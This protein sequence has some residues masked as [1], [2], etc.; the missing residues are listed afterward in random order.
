MITTYYSVMM[1][2]TKKNVFLKRI[3]KKMF[4]NNNDKKCISNDRI[5]VLIKI[6]ISI[7]YVKFDMI[8]QLIVSNIN[9]NFTQE[10]SVIEF[11][12]NKNSIKFEVN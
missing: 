6:S 1:K 10:K 2:N 5:I 7:C 9:N 8:L 3:Q 11:K 12:K 4:I